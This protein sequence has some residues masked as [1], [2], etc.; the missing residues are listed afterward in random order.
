MKPPTFFIIRLTEELKYD[1]WLFMK[2]LLVIIGCVLALA[3]TPIVTAMALTS[4]FGTPTYDR[5]TQ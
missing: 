4:T 1:T 5:C 2:N 3:G